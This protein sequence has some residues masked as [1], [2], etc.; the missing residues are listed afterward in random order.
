MLHIL[1]NLFG[2]LIIISYIDHDNIL[3]LYLK[4]T[5]LSIKKILTPI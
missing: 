3:A 1:L 4:K 2:I 5:I